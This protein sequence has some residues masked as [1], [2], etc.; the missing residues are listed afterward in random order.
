[1]KDNKEFYEDL[2]QIGLFFNSIINYDESM[3]LLEDFYSD[4]V[5]SPSKS[6]D[7]KKDLLFI[8]SKYDNEQNMYEEFLN[9]N[10][11]S[12]FKFDMKDNNDIRL[13]HLIFPSIAVIKDN[14][15]KSRRPVFNYSITF[16]KSLNLIGVDIRENGITGNY[17]AFFKRIKSELNEYIKSFNNF[18]NGKANKKDYELIVNK[19]HIIKDVNNISKRD[20]MILKSIKDFIKKIKSNISLFSDIVKNEEF[21][22]EKFINC[23]DIDKLYLIC[24]KCML[25]YA[26]DSYML[27]PGSFYTGINEI[28]N[29]LSKATD[30]FNNDYN[31]EITCYDKE[32]DEYY[33]FTFK[34]LKKEF[35]EYLSFFPNDRIKSL[36]YSEIKE[37][38]IS[39]P[40]EILAYLRK[41]ENVD[42]LKASW[43]F[44]KKGE[45]D[46]YTTRSRKFSSNKKYVDSESL[47]VKAYGRLEFFESTNYAAK[48]VGIDKFDG[49][50]GYI[51]NDGTVIFEKFFDDMEKR[52]P[53]RDGNATYVMNIYNFT[54]FSKLSKPEIINYI[55]NNDDGNIIRKYHTKN[56]ENNIKEIIKNITI[57]IDTQTAINR[58]LNEGR[59]K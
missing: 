24:S 45:K 57:D 41:R 42:T 35:N 34:D 5:M 18:L 22:I 29:Y 47:E 12:K 8:N 33:I 11:Y 51:Y 17:N 9:T 23:F 31:P 40:K 39:K 44:I 53:T 6:Y 55:K 10:F 3:F 48:I 58:L 28:L 2:N 21:N 56:W 16:A 14:K 1:M 46:E 37:N 32:K 52:R 49:Y 19:L 7:I 20:L 15:I 26:K 4:Y 38:N 59:I 27:A 25:D 30:E 36:S 50:I 43:E 13:K 54:E